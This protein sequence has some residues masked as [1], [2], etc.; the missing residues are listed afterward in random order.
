MNNRGSHWLRTIGRVREG[1]TREQAQADLSQVFVNLA[2]AYPDHDAGRTVRI[3][4]LS[5][6]LTEKSRGPLWTLLGAVLAILAIGCV[7]M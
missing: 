7:N 4:I 1:V 2:R 5:E 6:S 3:R